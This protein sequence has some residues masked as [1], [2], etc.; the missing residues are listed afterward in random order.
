MLLT[1]NLDL[2]E[3]LESEHFIIHFGL[4]NPMEGR[5]LGYGGIRDRILVLTYLHSL[6]TLYE[7]MRSAPWNREAPIV[8]KS[9][10]THVYVSNIVEPFTADDPFAQTNSLTTSRVPFIVLPCRNDATTTQTELQRASAEAVH[11]ATHLFNYTKRPFD[12]LTTNAWAWF[13]EGLAVYMETLVAAGNPEY[14]RYV[15]DWIDLPETPLDDPNSM[16]QACMFIRYLAKK[17]GHD[18]INKI[19]EDSYENETPLETIDRLLGGTNDFSSYLPAKDD[20]FGS[21]YC[22]DPYFLWDHGSISL[23]PDIFARYGERAVSHSLTL[24]PGRSE[25]I[26]GELDHLSCRYY[27]FY[28]KSDVKHLRIELQSRNGQGVAPLKATAAFVTVNMQRD[29]IKTLSNASTQADPV[30]VSADMPIANADVIHH[31][32]LIVSNCGT[33]AVSEYDA[34]AHDDGKEFLIEVSAS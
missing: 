7:V 23:A 26:E 3:K 10:K 5:G 9:K 33:R 31:I 21:G 20:M 34:S 32:V 28:L 29:L 19:W 15:M 16:Y 12:K 1:P 25:K 27:R 17:K 22:I 18:F 6:E 30:S 11:E 4:R 24:G 14:F 13:D 8:D 2:P